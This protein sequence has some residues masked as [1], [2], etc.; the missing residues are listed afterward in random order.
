[1]RRADAAGGV[2]RADAGD[3]VVMLDGVGLAGALGIDSAARLFDSHHHLAA[4]VSAIDYPVFVNGRNYGGT[5]PALTR[6]PVL[7]SL[8]RASLGPRLDMTPGALVIPLG[9]AAQGA[10]AFL[11]AEGLVDPAR[12]LLG[13]PHPSGAN[14]WRVRQYAAGG[15]CW[16]VRSPGG[17]PRP[18]A[19]RHGRF[20]LGCRTRRA[21]PLCWRLGRRVS[22]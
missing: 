10:L 1:M 16:P 13:F 20:W 12:C 5:S 21:C 6:H 22:L 15:I 3:L 2:F 18:A 11:A 14:G 17:L 8:V 19:A 7:R 9:K 4:H